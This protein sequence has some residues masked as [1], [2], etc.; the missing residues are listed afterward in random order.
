MPI[1]FTEHPIVRPPTDEEIVLLGEQDPQLL[2]DLHEA[3]EGRIKAAA[4]DPT[5]VRT[6]WL[7][8]YVR[9]L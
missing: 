7:G 8:A 6:T 1:T 9:F 2:A 4:E 3:H 5:R